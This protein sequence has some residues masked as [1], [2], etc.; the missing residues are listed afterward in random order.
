MTTRSNKIAHLIILNDI[1]CNGSNSFVAIPY[2]FYASNCIPTGSSWISEEFFYS[3]EYN[4]FFITRHTD[5]Q[6]NIC[7]GY[8]GCADK[9]TTEGKNNF[10]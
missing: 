6:I 5:S 8:Y 4:S 7:I 10:Q 9:N 1:S 2:L 3:I